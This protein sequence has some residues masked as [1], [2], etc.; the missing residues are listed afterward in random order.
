[1][2]EKQ[3]CSQSICPI[4]IA[5]K[6][7]GGKWKLSI[8]FSLTNGKMRFGQLANYIPNISRKVLTNQLKEMEKDGLI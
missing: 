5:M 8:I 1:M 4:S 6:T 2:E 3:T 7:L